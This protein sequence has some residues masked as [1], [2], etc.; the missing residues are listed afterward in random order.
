MQQKNKLKHNKKRNTAFLYE[1][2]VR[3]LTRCVVNGDIQIRNK[4]ITI[5]KK[6][7]NNSSPLYKELQLYTVLN[8]SANLEQ[9]FAERLVQEVAHMHS[10]LDQEQIFDEQTELIKTINK[11]LSPNV[12]NNFI[13][14]YKNIATIYQLFNSAAP[15]KE[16]I[17]LE[18]KMVDLLISK[19]ED[20]ESSNL[21]PI[22]NIVFNT[23][24]KKFNEKYNGTLLREQKE[25]LTRYVMSGTD[26]GI[27]L[28]LFLNEEIT[29]LRNK[30]Q[31]V[32][33]TEEFINNKFL[34]D[35][36]TKLFNKLDEFKKKPV[37]HGLLSDLLKIQN[38]IDEANK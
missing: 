7:F 18:Q 2:L 37:D 17:L 27:S 26:G 36:T 22:D 11:E 15:V 14:D 30:L 13:P 3:E 25:L 8:E 35:K 4:V 1:S 20:A 16:R 10:Q 19:P 28:N 38:F 23:F 9:R 24:V 33:K 32:L 34:T 5:C 6:F 21:E 31:E 12:F 29:R